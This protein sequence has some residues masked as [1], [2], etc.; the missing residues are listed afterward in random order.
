VH[1]RATHSCDAHK[2][3]NAVHAAAE[4]V[5][6]LA[7]EARRLA[8]H[9]PTEAGFDPPYTTL[10]VGNIT[11]DALPNTVPGRARFDVEWR[12][13]PTDDPKDALARFRTHVR[14]VIEPWMHALHPDTGFTYRVLLELPALSLPPQH[15]L[16]RAVCEIAGVPMGGK[17]SYCSEGSLYQPAGI[18]SAVC[19]PGD[20]AQAHQ[21][22]EWI[23]ETQLAACQDFIHRLVDRLAL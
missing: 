10:Q 14:T 15:Q 2:G 17:V 7:A 4:A 12:N 8:R 21:A 20:V 22:D 1:G 9:G 13:I 5:A 19:G 23:A 3:V 18:A 16:A 6:W 11:C